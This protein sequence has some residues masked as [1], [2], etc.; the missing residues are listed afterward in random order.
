MQFRT[1]ALATALAM[2]S[3][4][5]FAQMGG[6]NGVGAEVPENSG[7][8]VNSQGVGVGTV[9]EGRLI[10]R[11]P[12]TTTGSAP[13]GT[14]REINRGERRDRMTPQRAA[15]DATEDGPAGR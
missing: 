3:T 6:G 5:A 15:P 10:N 11:T 7:T 8:A 13:M 2:T 12:G 14:G 9:E 4:L 1:I